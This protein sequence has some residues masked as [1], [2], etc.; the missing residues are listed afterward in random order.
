MSFVR[1]DPPPSPKNKRNVTISFYGIFYVSP[2]NNFIIPNYRT[3][4]IYFLFLLLRHSIT[5]PPEPLPGL[6]SISGP[7]K[8]DMLVLFFPPA[9]CIPPDTDERQAREEDEEFIQA[10]QTLAR[11]KYDSP[12]PTSCLRQ[13]IKQDTSG[14]GSNRGQRNRQ[15]A[16]DTKRRRWTQEEDGV[17]ELACGGMAPSCINW[18]HVAS[19]VRQRSHKQCY[20]RYTEV[21]L[22]GYFVGLQPSHLRAWEI[23]M[24]KEYVALREPGEPK[25]WKNLCTEMSKQGHARQTFS[26]R[27]PGT[28]KNWWNNVK[29]K[30]TRCGYHSVT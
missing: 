15:P 25:Q 28:L 19:K 2:R 7:S 30:R 17:L 8:E 11:M 5:S 1:L 12:R 10:C 13:N 14:D 3:L 23:E 27:S 9:Y 4:F 18:R 21:L 16:R 24:I 29:N 6:P 26:Y 20:E 22:P